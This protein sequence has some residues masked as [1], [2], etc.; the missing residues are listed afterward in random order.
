[1]PEDPL[2]V[3]IPPP[4]WPKALQEQLTSNL[5]A[6]AVMFKVGRAFRQKH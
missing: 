2:D 3:V 4:R 5:V 6:A 1:M